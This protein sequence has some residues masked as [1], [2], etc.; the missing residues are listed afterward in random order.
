MKQC[1]L[2]KR[3]GEGRLGAGE[4]VERQKQGHELRVVVY[5]QDPS[6]ISLLHNRT[7]KNQKWK[8]YRPCMCVFSVIIVH[9]NLHLEANADEHATNVLKRRQRIQTYSWR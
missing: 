5:G 6:V 2:S 9:T 8:L 3:S 7:A 4:G 1:F